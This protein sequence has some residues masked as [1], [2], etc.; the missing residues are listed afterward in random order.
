[1]AML[2]VSNKWLR[3]RMLSAMQRRVSMVTAAV[4]SGAANAM[5]SAAGDGSRVG[6]VR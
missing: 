3:I 6:W 1:M 5:V 4:S 2:G